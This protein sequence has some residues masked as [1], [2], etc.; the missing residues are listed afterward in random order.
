VSLELLCSES[1]VQEASKGNAVAEELSLGDWGAP[2]HHGTA[3]QKDVLEN[4]TK[5]EDEG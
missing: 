2:D 3:N 1:V 4:T 5:G